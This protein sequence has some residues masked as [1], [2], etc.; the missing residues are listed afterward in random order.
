MA[1]YKIAVLGAYVHSDILVSGVV[2]GSLGDV[3]VLVIWPT[4]HK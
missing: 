4:W 2:I 1:V 3:D